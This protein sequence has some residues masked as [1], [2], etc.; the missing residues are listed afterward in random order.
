MPGRV[1]M[2]RFN[3]LARKAVMTTHVHR[4]RGIGVSTGDA[5]TTHFDLLLADDDPDYDVTSNLTTIAECEAKSRLKSIQLNMI[6]KTTQENHTLEW[7]LYR[8]PDEVLEAGGV[9]PAT[10]FTAD[11]TAFTA[12]LRK[13][14]LAYGFFRASTN[15]DAHSTR[16]RISRKAMRRVVQMNDLDRI[17]LA[18]TASDVVTAGTIDIWGR[19]VTQK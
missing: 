10:L 8:D 14:A 13:N 17:K 9:T 19:I 5:A 12:L 18:I 3:N 1:S 2:R 11:V 16:I 6:L 7:M 15:K 4:V